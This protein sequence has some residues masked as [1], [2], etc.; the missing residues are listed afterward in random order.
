MKRNLTEELIDALEVKRRRYIVMDKQVPWLGVRVSPTGRKSFVM[1]ARFNASNPT[2][3]AL[4]KLTL[5][6]AREKVRSWQRSLEQGID[7]RKQRSSKFGDV[8]GD[9]F[10]HIK[11][12]RRASE[13]ERIVRKRLKEWWNKPIASITKQDAIDAIKSVKDQG[14]LCSAHQL[15]AHMRRVFNYAID[16][17]VLPHSPCD[18]L[19]ARGLI[20]E[21]GI[22]QRVLND[23][24]IRAVWLACERSGK[25]GKLCQLILATGARRGEAAGATPAEFKIEL[26]KLWT[27]PAHRFKSNHAHLVPLSSLALDIAQHVPL[28]ATGF[29][30]SKKRLDK[31]VLIELRKR[32]PNATLPNYTLHDLRR[33]VRTRLSELRVPEHVAEAVIGHAKVG[34]N[35]VY[36]LHEYLDEKRE[37]LDAWDER[38]KRIIARDFS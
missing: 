19:R 12:Q 31:L 35:R 29:D 8:A 9:W 26:Y 13:A 2:R 38:L 27:V 30:K 4:G 23:E 25:F 1:V 22:R 36:N 17:N 20:G 10:K 32:N 24:E 5:E 37:A 3:A 16:N 15:L 34:L 18:R 6:Q 14:K 21:R 7:P 28:S 11:H 33:T